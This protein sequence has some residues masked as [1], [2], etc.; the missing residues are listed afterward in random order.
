MPLRDFKCLTC[1]KVQ[2]RFYHASAGS[3]AIRCDCGG[4]LSMLER[5]DEHARPFI[6]V[7]FPFTTPHIDPH[8]RPIT[9]ES[10]GH[11]RSLERQYGVVLTAFSN[12]NLDDHIP[13]PPR[14]RGWE[15]ERER[16][17]RT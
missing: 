15:V 16:A 9:V 13:N 17:R 4:P 8:G 12:T 2:E 3:D 14:Y 6:G 7:S 11:L 5:S 1:E 10:M